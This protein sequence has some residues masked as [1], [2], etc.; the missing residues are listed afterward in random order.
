M[1]P[2]DVS[3]KPKRKWARKKT[4][5]K[6]R[7]GDEPK[8]RETAEIYIVNDANADKKEDSFVDSDDEKNLDKKERDVNEDMLNE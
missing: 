3:Q 5:H 7:K 8:K 2:S 4:K 1:I 6:K